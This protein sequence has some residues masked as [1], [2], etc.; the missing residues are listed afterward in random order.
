MIKHM[1]LGFQMQEALATQ[2]GKRVLKEKHTDKEFIATGTLAS[3]MQ[4]FLLIWR[5]FPRT[6]QI[7][8]P[9]KQWVTMYG[10]HMRFTQIPMYKKVFQDTS[11]TGDLHITIHFDGEYKNLSHKEVKITCMERFQT[12]NISL[13]VAYSNPIDIGINTVSWNWVVFIKMYLQHPKQNELALLQGERA[14]V[15]TMRDGENI[16]GNIKK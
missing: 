6:K 11:L 7:L 1:W 16:V 12:M 15:M 10:Q 14:F 2:R 9:T 13:S 4:R 3:E 5:A 8:F